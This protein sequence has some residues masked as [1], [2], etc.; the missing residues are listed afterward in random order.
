MS[1]S[2]FAAPP[3]PISSAAVALTNSSAC[4][5]MQA[6]NNPEKQAADESGV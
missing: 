5:A 4:V 2:R 3:H 6:L 1:P